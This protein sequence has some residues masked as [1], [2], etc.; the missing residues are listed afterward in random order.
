[1]NFSQWIR[2]CQLRNPAECASFQETSQPGEERILEAPQDLERSVFRKRKVYCFC[3]KG[4][5]EQK[6]TRIL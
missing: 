3:K 1:M 2:Y 4:E 5:T 6:F